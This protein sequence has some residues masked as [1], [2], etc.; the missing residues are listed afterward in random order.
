ML[1]TSKRVYMIVNAPC[2]GE[3]RSGDLHDHF[4]EE[5][6]KRLFI[7]NLMKESSKHAKEFSMIKLKKSLNEMI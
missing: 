6:L 7:E 1:T 2:H 4:P 3:Q 5:S